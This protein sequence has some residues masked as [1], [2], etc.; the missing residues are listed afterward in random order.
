MGGKSPKVDK[1]A[2]RRQEEELAKLKKEEDSRVAALKRS[3]R[4]RASL[5]SGEEGGVRDT[6]G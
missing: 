6:L 3:R 4:G 5:I 2:Q 1:A